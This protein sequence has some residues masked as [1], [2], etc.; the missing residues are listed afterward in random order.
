MLVAFLFPVAML[1][2]TALGHAS[3]T[4]PKLTRRGLLA[5]SAAT[6]IAATQPKLLLNALGTALN[7]PIDPVRAAREAQLIAE[8]IGQAFEPNSHEFFFTMNTFA[9]TESVPVARLPPVRLPT[10]VPTDHFAAVI[11]ELELDLARQFPFTLAQIRARGEHLRGVERLEETLSRDR[12]P[13]QI[14]NIL[15]RNFD[16]GE[17]FDRAYLAGLTRVHPTYAAQAEAR[18]EGLRKVGETFISDR[19]A[20][21]LAFWRNFFNT[22]ERV[23]KAWLFEQPEAMAYDSRLDSANEDEQY[24]RLLR[25]STMKLNGFERFNKFVSGVSQVLAELEER[26]A[27][28]NNMDIE[29]VYETMAFLLKPQRSLPWST[30]GYSPRVYPQPSDAFIQ[31]LMTEIPAVAPSLAELITRAA[32]HLKTDLAARYEMRG[33]AFSRSAG[34][35]GR[36]IARALSRDV[37]AH[38]CVRRTRT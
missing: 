29:A 18:W 25:R 9:D 4:G 10:E 36:R 32:D 24:Y 37:R 27:V 1:L 26:L 7:P 33:W 11:A 2:Q 17:A 21:R 5:G 20:W 31:K 22:E 28:E 15:R 6:A 8:R 14:P 34:R 12:L 3:D 35:T 13:L 23:F 38:A 30:E 16:L 19:K